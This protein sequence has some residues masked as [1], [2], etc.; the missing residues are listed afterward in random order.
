M[1]VLNSYKEKVYE[2]VV[3]KI[4]PLM[5]VQS[6]TFLVEA[7]FV[8]Q[9]DV[10][11]PNITFEASIFIQSK[12]NALLIPR[13]YLLND[14]IVT[15]SD[16]KEVVVKTGLKDYQMVEI[17]SGITEDDELIKPEK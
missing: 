12:K 5:D 16:G 11:Y 14:S 3:S 10:L 6:K 4:N 9:P 17:L 7:E 8:Q 2:A 1:V 13:E 15:K